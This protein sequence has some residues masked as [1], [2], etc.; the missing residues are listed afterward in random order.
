MSL[1]VVDADVLGRQRTGDETYVRNLLRTLARPAADAGLRV[2]AVTRRPDLVPDGIEAVELAGR[3]QELRMVWTLPRTLRR[4]GASLV[5]TQY[6]VPLRRPC[7]AVVTIHDL[8]FERGL[9][10]RRDRIVFE[11]VVPR[12][13]RTAARVLTVSERTKRD[14]VAHYGVPA[15]R[16]VVTPNGVDPAF[17]HRVD[18]ARNTV[19]G[20]PYALAVGAIQERKN[21]QA[22]LAAA[23]EA[24]LELVLVGPT[25]D[26]R[27]ARGLRAAGARLEGYVPTERLAELYRGAACLVQAS[28][29]EG[30]GLPVVEAMASGTPVVT[31]PDPALV[32][33]AGD[34]AV[35]VAESELADGIRRAIAERDR[36]AAAGLAR[37]RD[38]S[39]EATAEATVRVYLEA[40]GA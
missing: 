36:L 6:A 18:G 13:A 38:F 27:V 20:A 11:R 26:E 5:H 21:H 31:V 37:S 4:L 34:A 7:P 10:P 33:V 35:V 40:L 9:M 15:E 24:G 16:I 32:E 19:T 23:R 22:A 3:V 39:W 28:R 1:V 14:I 17:G 12:A 8:S 2:A 25:K 30:F 29:H